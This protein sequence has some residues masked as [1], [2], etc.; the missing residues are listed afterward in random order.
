M[1]S[2]CISDIEALDS[3][4]RVSVVWLIHM[5]IELRRSRRSDFGTFVLCYN[6]TVQVGTALWLLLVMRSIIKSLTSAVGQTLQ[7]L[8]SVRKNLGLH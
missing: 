6:G 1:A 4:A 8:Q 2:S 7:V 5:I 3:T